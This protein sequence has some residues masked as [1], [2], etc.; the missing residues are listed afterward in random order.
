MTRRIAVRGIFVYQGKLLCAKLKPYNRE[1]TEDFW[2]TIGGGVDDGEQILD[3]LSREIVEETGIAPV[4]GNLLY[5]HQYM[6]DDIESTEFFFYIKNAADYVAVDLAKTSHGLQEIA[7]LAFIDPSTNYVL[8]KFL[9]T[10][11]YS[12]LGA[13][14]A[15]HFYSYM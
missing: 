3:A 9:Q 7:E 13:V 11:D 5:V 1:R 6:Q 8:P 14:Q 4:I 12:A 10:Q 15:V 2:C